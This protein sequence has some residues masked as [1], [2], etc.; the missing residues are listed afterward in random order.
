MNEM[1]CKDCGEKFLVEHWATFHE[2]Q[3]VKCPKCSSE[4][5]GLP[6]RSKSFTISTTYIK[7]TS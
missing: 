7:E 2:G 5:I 6:G 3:K 4:N 1:E